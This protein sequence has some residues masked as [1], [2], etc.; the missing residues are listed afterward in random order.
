MAEVSCPGCGASV[1]AAGI[2][3]FC[4]GTA[5][6]DGVPGRLLP[7]DLRCPRCEGRPLQGVEHEGLRADVCTECHGVWFGTGMLEEAVRLAA[8]RPVRKGEGGRGPAH[9]GME[10]VRYARCPR[11]DGGMARVA[12]ARRPL[13]IIDR[14]P[15]H[16]H[17]CDGGEFGQ[18]KAVARSRGVAE[19]LG[20]SA[21][22]AAPAGRIPA[23]PEGDPL[24]AELKRRPGNWGLV[25][26][27]VSQADALAEVRRG[28]FLTWG[29]GRRR[30]TLFDILW[31]ILA[32]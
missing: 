17:W 1:P 16:G 13:V 32:R 5:F 27:E 24:L 25:P 9:G 14:C 6:V 26:S 18:L 19:A 15:S 2:C 11:C 30:Y 7:S 23:I 29:R 22:A 20:G 4:N 12:L 28:D 10:P 31:R 21:E 3:R 8:A